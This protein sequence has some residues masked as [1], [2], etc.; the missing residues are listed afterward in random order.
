[1]QIFLYISMVSVSEIPFSLNARPICC[2]LG[3]AEKHKQMSACHRLC[4]LVWWAVCAWWTL[5]VWW[6]WNSLSSCAAEG[7]GPSSDLTIEPVKAILDNQ[8]NIRVLAPSH[9][10]LSHRDLS[11]LLLLFC[12]SSLPLEF[13]VSV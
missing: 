10:T 13:I 5:D 6:H 9:L 4:S 12:Y 7:L 3:I 8:P 1:M 2:S 11:R